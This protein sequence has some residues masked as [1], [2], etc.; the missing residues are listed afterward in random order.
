MNWQ[1][2]GNNVPQSVVGYSFAYDPLNRLARADFSAYD[3]TTWQAT[4]AYDVGVTQPIRYDPNGNLLA[5]PRHGAQGHEASLIYAYQPGSNR[6]QSVQGGL[7]LN[8]EPPPTPSFLDGTVAYQYDYNGNQTQGR[9]LDAIQYD[10]RNLPVL[11]QT[12]R[13]VSLATGYDPSGQRIFKS[14]GPETGTFYL[15]D[16]QGT[17]VA[18]YQAGGSLKYWNIVAGGSVIG[19][20]EPPQTP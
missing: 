14:S 5:L 12:S 2:E 4:A 7:F 13:G 15:R 9:G 10:R 18:V 17:V 16:P 1:T 8:T 20:I 3:G 11:M 19:R 6:I